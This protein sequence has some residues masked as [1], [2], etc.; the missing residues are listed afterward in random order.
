MSTGGEVALAFASNL[1]QLGQER[2][3]TKNKLDSHSSTDALH[4]L[5]YVQPAINTVVLRW[6]VNFRFT[7]EVP[8]ALRQA[9]WRMHT[10]PVDNRLEGFV[11]KA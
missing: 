11:L 4:E 6:N 9:G 7:L 8:S 5:I 2:T 1:K 10:K 3:E